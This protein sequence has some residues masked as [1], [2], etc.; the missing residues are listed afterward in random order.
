[1]RWLRGLKVR[2]S[3][4]FHSH[5]LLNRPIENYAQ[6]K[7][8]YTGRVPAAPLIPDA[9]HR[10]LSHLMDHN[11]HARKYLAMIPDARMY[12]FNAVLTKY[13]L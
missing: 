7:R 1:M 5:Q 6:M 8:I 12:W 4:V 13:Y 9:V 11:A 10:A 2:K 3:G